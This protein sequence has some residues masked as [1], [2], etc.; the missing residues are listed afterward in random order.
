MGRTA[1]RVCFGIWV[2][3]RISLE[4]MLCTS[5]SAE[6]SRP[7]VRRMKTKVFW[8]SGLRSTPLLYRADTETLHELLRRMRNDGIYRRDQRVD[9]L[10][11]A[12]SL[13]SVSRYTGWITW[14]NSTASSR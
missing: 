8:I 11:R 13:W 6:E 2:S 5:R 9:L 7:Q 14:V 3:F 12:R 1:A 10:V 4:S